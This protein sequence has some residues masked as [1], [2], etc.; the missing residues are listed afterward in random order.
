MEQMAEQWKYALPQGESTMGWEGVKKVRDS[1]Y[2]KYDKMY[3]GHMIWDEKRSHASFDFTVK[4]FGEMD[5]KISL[6]QM[7]AQIEYFMKNI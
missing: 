1:F 4:I 7:M 2:P 6:C 5:D 3:G